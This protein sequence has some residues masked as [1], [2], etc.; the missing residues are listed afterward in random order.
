M[1]ILGEATFVKNYSGHSALKNLSIGKK[2]S[3]TKRYSRAK[4]REYNPKLM[5]GFEIIKDNGESEIYF[6][7]HMFNVNWFNQ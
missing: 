3:I 5:D 7:Y 6:S 1:E 4:Y 2:Y